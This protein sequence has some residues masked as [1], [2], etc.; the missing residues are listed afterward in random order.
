MANRG[1]DTNGTK[2]FITTRS[3]D[4]LDGSHVCFGKVLKGMVGVFSNAIL[5]LS[6]KP[7]IYFSLRIS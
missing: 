3:A 6:V 1:V 7:G 2:F 5:K 4:W